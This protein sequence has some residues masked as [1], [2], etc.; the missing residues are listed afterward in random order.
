VCR[1]VESSSSYRL[2]FVNFL[3]LQVAVTS[4]WFSSKPA[5]KEL[6]HEKDKTQP[7]N[8]VKITAETVIDAAHLF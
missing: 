2:Y 7:D 1:S 4:E 3:T 8:G 5:L 6:P